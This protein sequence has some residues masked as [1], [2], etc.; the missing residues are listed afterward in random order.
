MELVYSTK[1]SQYQYWTLQATLS[2][3]LSV[4]QGPTEP[5]QLYH[6]LF[7][8]QVTAM[9][10]IWGPFYPTKH[11]KPLETN[12]TDDALLKTQQ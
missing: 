9:E 4:Q 6:R 12:G 1:D 11:A 3:M 7:M 8:E 5:P 10:A 2:N